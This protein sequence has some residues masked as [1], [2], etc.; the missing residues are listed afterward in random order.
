[1]KAPAKSVSF[2]KVK[3]EDI[4]KKPFSRPGT[5]SRFYAVLLTCIR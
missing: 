2:I 1:M 4:K 3:N 5:A